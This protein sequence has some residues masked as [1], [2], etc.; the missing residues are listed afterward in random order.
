MH[1]L[2][3]G[4]VS[5]SRAPFLHGHPEF[6]IKNPEISLF[7][8]KFS[9]FFTSLKK[10]CKKRDNFKT[11]SKRDGFASRRAKLELKLEDLDTGG[12]ACVVYKIH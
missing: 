7:I 6:L 4:V 5:E 3:I 8:E 11:P 9:Y 2:H 12:A 10:Y 1:Y